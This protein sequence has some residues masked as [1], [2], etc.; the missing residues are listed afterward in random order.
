V[1]AGWA[2][3]ERHLPALRR[4]PRAR[5]VG[6]VDKHVGRA[7]A[8]ARAVGAAHWG[9]S[10]DE[11]WLAN[12]DCLTIGTP[13]PTHAALI[14]QALDRGWHCLCEKPLAFPASE[15]K[16]LVGRAEELGLVLAVVHNFQFSPSGSRLFELVES[17]RLGSVKAVYGFQLSNPAR[18]L[19]H[20]H[21]A[22][23][24]GLFLDEAPH[25]LYLTRRIVGEL[26]TG[27]VAAHVRTNELRHLGV[28][29]EHENIW[30]SL[31]MSFDASISEWQLLVVCDRGVACLDVFRD[32]FVLVPN[33]GSHRA[34]EILRT[35]GRMVAGHVMGVASSGV[36][37]AGHRL[38]YGNDEVVRRFFDA[39]DGRPGRLRW[40]SGRDGHAV[41]EAIEE[42]LTRAG[43]DPLQIPEAQS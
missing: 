17:G 9:N 8:A 6:I 21:T 19:P 31:S 41:V 34:R 39:V 25:L 30:A 37:L 38:S 24:G 29:F 40:M 14:E 15:A 12:V 22:L 18:R 11:P 13:P 33:D 27:S 43:I 32:I 35:S 2:T 1:G 10:V 36:R 7:E 28:T 3:R 16:R 23:P 20:W 5:V 42:I 4:D 26:R